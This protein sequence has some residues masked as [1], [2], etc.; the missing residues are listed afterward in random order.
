MKTLTFPASPL[1]PVIAEIKA[2]RFRPVYIVL[3]PDPTAADGLIALLKERL[4]VSGLEAFDS[5]TVQGGDIGKSEGLSVEMLLQRTK[6]PPVAAKRRLIIIRH[7]ERLDK[8]TLTNLGTGLQNVPDS[9]T[10]VAL[11]DYDRDLKKVLERCGLKKYLIS[12]PGFKED[13]LRAQVGAWAK[14]SGLEMTP[15]AI[16]MLIEIAGEDGAILKGEI[17]KLATA[18]EPG[19]RVSIAAVKEY[20][21]S[22]RV[23]ELR[24]YVWHCLDRNAKKAL[25]LLHKLEEAGEEPIRIIAWLTNALLD[26]LAVKKGVRST[27]SLWRVSKEA[28][29]RWSEESLNKALHKLYRINVDILKGYPEPFALLDIWTFATGVKE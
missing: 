15:E 17:G 5:E 3:S 21:S 13:D 6:Q 7:L 11:C 28:P 22:T 4:L 23:F 24:D 2:G 12:L 8:E 16:E 18:F 20:T 25:T 26:V 29:R 10:V 14:K 9:T 27:D 19:S 1:A